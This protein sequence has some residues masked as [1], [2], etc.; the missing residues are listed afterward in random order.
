MVYKDANK[1]YVDILKSLS[2]NGNIT[3]KRRELIFQTYT[4]ND[5][6]KNILF[7]PFAQRNWPWILRECSDRIMGI[8]NPGTSAKY[9]SNWE[10]RKEQ[11]GLYSY[12]YSDRLK[13]QMKNCLST[14][15]QARDKIISVWDREDFFTKSRQPCTIIMQPI[16]EYDKKMSL[17]VYMRNNDMINIFPSDIF[18]HSTYFKYWCANFGIEYKNLYWVS[19][20]AYYQKKRDEMKFVDRLLKD[21]KDDYRSCKI[22]SSTWN[23]DF[24]EDFKN[25]EIFESLIEVNPDPEK[26]EESLSKFKTNYVKEWYKVMLLAYFKKNKKKKEFKDIFD[27]EFKTEF[28][29]IKESIKL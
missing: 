4:L 26:I 15:P 8:P 5:L 20:V 3:G 7:F 10:N 12:H 19:A 21:W 13:D 18:I 1:L 24:I 11:S 28:K 25:K 23:K 2:T 27:S 29:L 9:S 16:L 6:D 14:K 17:I 22:K